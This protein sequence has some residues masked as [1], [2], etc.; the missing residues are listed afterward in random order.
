MAGS[1]N[2][3]SLRARQEGMSLI[4]MLILVVVLIF[5]LVIAVRLTPVYLESMEVGS[6]LNSMEQD[7]ELQGASRTELRQTLQRYLQVNGIQRIGRDDIGFSDTAGGTL[8]VIEYEARVPLIFNLDA[9]AK[10]RKE[11]VVRQ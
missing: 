10:F 6:I 2:R 1:N 7:S 5:A 11:A 8:M 9:V 4:A 3:R